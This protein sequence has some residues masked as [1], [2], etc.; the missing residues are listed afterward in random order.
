VASGTD[1]SGGAALGTAV[2]H[3]AADSALITA[4]EVGRNRRHALFA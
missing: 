1:R 2:G 3:F 4:K